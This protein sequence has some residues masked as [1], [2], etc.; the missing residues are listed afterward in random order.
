MHFSDGSHFS[1][2][3]VRLVPQLTRSL[4]SVSKHDDNHCRMIF[5]SQSCRIMKGNMI[6]AKGT[7]LVPSTHYSFL[8]RN[9][10]WLSQTSL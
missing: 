9:I 8:K 1:M 5:D 3:D 6:I 7:K 4:M 2:K 10:F